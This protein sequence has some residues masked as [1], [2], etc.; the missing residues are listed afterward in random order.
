MV[1]PAECLAAEVDSIQTSA[2]PVG[3]VVTRLAEACVAPAAVV[4]AVRQLT[5]AEEDSWVAAAYSMR[6]EI[7]D[8]ARAAALVV[9]DMCTTTASGAMGMN[10]AGATEAHSALPCSSSCGYGDA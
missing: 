9:K 10:G 3:L 6:W 1:F 7:A 8:M 5:A 2:A 4:V